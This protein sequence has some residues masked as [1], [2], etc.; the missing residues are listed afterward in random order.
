VPPALTEVNLEFPAEMGIGTSGLGVETCERTMLEALG[1]EGCPPDSLMGFGTVVTEI[2]AAQM[3]LRENNRVVVVRGPTEGG[4][5]SFFI[6]ATGTS[7]VIT[8]LTFPAV[9]VPAR[10]PYGETLQAQIPLI[11]SFPDAADVAVVTMHATLGS[12]ALRYE[13]RTGGTVVSYHP[14]GVL[15]PAG[16]RPGGFRFAAKF[17]FADG[18]HAL[19]RTSVRCPTS[20]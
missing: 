12:P 5:L 18:S 19:A 14:A 20:G 7:P 9:L 13:E 4:H 11:P 2:P 1:V 16:C 8:D 10:A 17:G 6:Q 3:R 15:L